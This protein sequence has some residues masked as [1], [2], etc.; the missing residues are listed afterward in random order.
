MNLTSSM[1]NIFTSPRQVFEQF[2]STIRYTDWLLPLVIILFSVLITTQLTAPITQAF[3]IE[4]IENN[5]DITDE[6]KEE[7]FE[8]MEGSVSGTL[9][10]VFAIGGTIIWYLI[11]SGILMLMGSM[12]L[13]GDL[14]YSTVWT[15]TILVGLISIPELIIKVPIMV[16]SGNL[17][18]ET[19]LSLILPNSLNGTFIYNLFI[20]LDFFSIWRIILYSLGLS[21]LFDLDKN[22]TYAVLFGGWF[23]VSLITAVF[24][25]R[26][27][28]TAVF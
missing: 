5:P 26:S 9:T 8:E 23:A 1:I 21:I 13:G 18:V 15:M 7:I 11:L 10:S 2:P 16:S 19:G 17:N 14:D 12:I 22:K 28:V 25:S 24:L 20:Q 4:M 6:Q 27:G 3:Q